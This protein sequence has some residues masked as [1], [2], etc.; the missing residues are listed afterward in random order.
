MQSYLAITC[1]IVRTIF[2]VGPGFEPLAL[3]TIYFVGPGFEPLPMQY[4]LFVGLGFG[5][6]ALIAHFRPG[7]NLAY[8]TCPH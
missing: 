5:S 3:H 8:I 4:Y 6:L 7:V 1:K 2:L